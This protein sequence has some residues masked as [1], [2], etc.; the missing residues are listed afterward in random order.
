MSKNPVDMLKENNT[1][2]DIAQAYMSKGKSSAR[3]QLVGAAILGFLGAKENR[4]IADTNRKLRAL[5][6]EQV[7][8]QAN[9][10]R[11]WEEHTKVA[12]NHK[13]YLNDNNYFY[14]L[15]EKEFDDKNP[16]YFESQFGLNGRSQ[17]AIALREKEIKEKSDFLK[18]NHFLKM[19]YKPNVEGRFDFDEVTKLPVSTD[20]TTQIRNV[21]QTEQQFMAPFENY[22]IAKQEALLA[23][24]NI[25][26][27]HG[28]LNKRFG[29][30]TKV[31]DPLNPTQKVTLR[32]L[33][34]R[35]FDRL[36]DV[37][38]SQIN[39]TSTPIV[40]NEELIKNSAIP[41]FRNI[42]A[43]GYNKDTKETFTIFTVGK[44]E[45]QERAIISLQGYSEGIRKN[46][47]KDI[48]GSK[49]TEFS[50]TDLQGIIFS[51]VSKNSELENQIKE[52]NTVYDSNFLTENANLGITN[53]QEW[54][55]T[56][57]DDGPTEEKR[58]SYLQGR[59]QIIHKYLGVSDKMK[60]NMVLIE[61]AK[62]IL[63]PANA[64]K[65]S[66]AQKQMAK[67]ELS[68]LGTS[69]LEATIIASIQRDML[70]EIEQQKRSSLYDRVDRDDNNNVIGVGLKTTDING[71]ITYITNETEYAANRYSLAKQLIDNLLSTD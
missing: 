58:L 29:L 68:D 33:E 67:K 30:E 4:M 65:Y 47:L 66:N 21:Q 23:P 45:A 43:Q 20:E 53:L 6:S 50:I 42:Y 31:E 12:D 11:L 71:N 46:V 69:S 41:R 60:D 35:A 36:V 54:S 62:V 51:R 22:I 57:K 26:W 17:A 13:K 25:G 24:E 28:M 61:R 7:V 27:A 52:A 38:K 32:E 9:A 56:K 55:E 10:L 1:W 34:T 40:T 2:E 19:N 5:A 70:D 18:N 44:R 39:L 59:T 16:N 8:E 49:K 63:D 64:S 48:V 14:S 3:K 37:K 15:A